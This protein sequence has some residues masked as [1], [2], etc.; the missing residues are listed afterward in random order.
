MFL[1][2]ARDR[3]GSAW[4]DR[5]RKMG[6]AKPVACAYAYWCIC[7][8]VRVRMHEYNQVFMC[9]H[10]HACVRACLRACVCTRVR[11]CAI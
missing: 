4:M 10:L 6:L 3:Q 8:V 1:L 2:V 5:G 7:A 11:G 9:A